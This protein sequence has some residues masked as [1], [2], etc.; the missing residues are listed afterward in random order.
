VAG[1]VGS[2]DGGS[3]AFGRISLVDATDPSLTIR[4]NIQPDGSFHI[5][6]VPAGTYTLQVSGAS[7]QA[8]LVPNRSPGI[9]FSPFSQQVVVH[10]S[11]L[12]D[13][14]LNLAPATAGAAQ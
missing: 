8:G 7:S 14:D 1:H 4:T 9:G 13:L 12:T 5:P 11:D 3:V 6:Y 2:A 10:E